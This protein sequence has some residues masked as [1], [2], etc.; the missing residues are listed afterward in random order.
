MKNLHIEPEVLAAVHSHLEAGYPNEAVGFLYGSESA[1]R[2]ITAHLP[3]E[4]AK[5]GDQRRR[6]EVSPVDYLRAEAYAETQ[7]LELLG[8]YHSHPDHPAQPSEHDLKS[9][10]PFFSYLIVSVR[11][12]QAGETTSW[13]LDEA[14]QFREEFLP[15]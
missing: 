11:N 1:V 5:P 2:H 4:N 13:Q 3:V 12:G 8:I 15:S 14:G 6:F 7:G 10:L 9:A